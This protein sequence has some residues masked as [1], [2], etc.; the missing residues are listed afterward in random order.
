MKKLLVLI[1]SALM[2]LTA[3]ACGG[4]KNKCEKEAAV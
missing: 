3:V 1:L 2:I 4:D